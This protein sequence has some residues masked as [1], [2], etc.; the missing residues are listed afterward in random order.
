M[1]ARQRT[2]AAYNDSAARQFAPWR[3]L[4][5]VAPPVQIT[6]ETHPEI[7]RAIAHARKLRGEA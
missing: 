2:I 6:D 1:T 5:P 7:A 4:P 3:E